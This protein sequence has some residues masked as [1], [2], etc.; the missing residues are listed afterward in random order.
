MTLNRK[1]RFALLGLGGVGSIVARELATH[2]RG[3]IAVVCDLKQ[4]V[5]LEVMTR[6][7]VHA[8]FTPDW[9]QAVCRSDVDAVLIQTP[10][11]LHEGPF[12]AALEQNKHVS[13]QKPFAIT[14]GEVLRMATA[15]ANRPDLV[16]YVAQCCRMERC[17]Q[18][19]REII[20]SNRIGT[21]HHIK[22][23]YI[24]GYMHYWLAETASGIDKRWRLSPDSCG[25]LD[26]GVHAFDMVRFLTGQEAVKVY[27][28]QSTPL[29]T[30]YPHSAMV[31]A[32]F[33]LG[34]GATAVVASTFGAVSPWRPAMA[35][36][37]YGSRGTIRNGR[38]IYHDN[39]RGWKP[40]PDYSDFYAEKKIL[41]WPSEMV[42]APHPF[43]ME[44]DHMID[45]IQHKTKSLTPAWSG[46]MSALGVIK[47]MESVERGMPVDTPEKVPGM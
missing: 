42:G 43:R 15:A 6:C 38:M 26:G 3:E 40:Q 7:G 18:A 32:A 37:I 27:A 9:K 34:G 36:E 19:V 29:M 35:L 21:I 1:I 28:Q 2:S 22:I 10:N 23:D 33:A 12:V 4:D 47:A 45:C 8:D 16:T 41:G 44:I 25:M 24:T 11:Q 5:A 39:E 13:I 46:A 17:Y 31:S 30:E 14:E 20:S